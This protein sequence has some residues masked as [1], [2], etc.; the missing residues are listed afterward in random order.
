MGTPTQLKAEIETRAASDPEFAAMYSSRNDNGM[1]AALSA[2]RTKLTE[3]MLTERKIMSVLGIVDGEAALSSLETFC[4][5]TPADPTLAQVHPGIKRMV[6][7]LKTTGI[8][9]GNPLTQSMLDLLGATGVLSTS[10]V[11]QLKAL[12]VVPDPISSNQISEAI[13]HG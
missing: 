12:A 8:D 10:S 1:A 11:N 6:T 2:G 7:W 4:T 9:V 5:G 13:D 3:T